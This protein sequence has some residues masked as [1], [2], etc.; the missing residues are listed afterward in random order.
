[1]RWANSVHVNAGNE[2]GERAMR[3]G[4][5]DTLMVMIDA[6]LTLTEQDKYILESIC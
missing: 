6:L 2:K 3:S 1:M 5:A 4:L